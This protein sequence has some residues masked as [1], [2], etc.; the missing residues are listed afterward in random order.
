MQRRHEINDE[1]WDAIKGYLPG[2]KGHIGANAKDNKSFVN[3]VIW[4]LRTGAPWRD[5]PE[6]YGNWKNVH[7]R[8]SRWAQKGVWEKIFQELAK[9]SDME[10]LMLDST[11]T[12]AHQHSAGARKEKAAKTPK[13]SGGP[14]EVLAPRYI[15]RSIITATL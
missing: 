8:M 15:L 14:E 6:R 3:G 13:P 7:R 9:T 10:V 11:I 5:L 1:Q 4:V 12:R 2:I